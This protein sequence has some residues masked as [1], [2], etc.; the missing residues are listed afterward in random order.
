MR[1]IGALY[2]F[3]DSK[4][5]S[6][7]GRRPSFAHK[8]ALR[9]WR[10]RH[11]HGDGLPNFGAVAANSARLAQFYAPLLEGLPPPTGRHTHYRHLRAGCT[12]C[13]R[14]NDTA[15]PT[16]IGAA[17]LRIALLFQFKKNILVR[18]AS[19]W[20]ATLIALF[21]SSSDVPTL[22]CCKLH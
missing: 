9:C 12:F 19:I 11:C 1:R 18:F 14:A 8:G 20:L 21:F 5:T 22:D 2:V 4:G 17:K 13:L 10:Q 15:Q 7:W 3:L 6:N 16:A